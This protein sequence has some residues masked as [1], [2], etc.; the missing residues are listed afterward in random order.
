[1]GG[2]AAVS[3]P[4]P[5]PPQS[6][7]AAVHRR[8]QEL[9]FDAVGIVRPDSIAEAGGRL[10]TFLAEGRHGTMTW[11]ARR[12]DERADPRALWT[13]TRSVVVVGMN[14]PPASDPLADTR[15]PR[16]GT[17]ASYARGRDYHDV[18]KRRLKQLG[19]WLAEEFGAG[20]KV[21]VDTAPVLEKALSE[22][23]GLG[24]QGKHTNL[25]SRVFGSWL[26]LGEVFTTL[27]LPPDSPGGDAC[28]TCRRCLEIC[29]T[30]AFPAP[31]QLD[32]RRCISYLTIE[33]KGHIAEE[34]RA[35]IGNRVFGCDDCL[36]VCPWNKYAQKAAEASFEAREETSAPE[37]GD[38]AALDDASFRR[39]FAGTTVKRTG[40]HR[41]VRNVL[42]AV[43]NS[44]DPRLSDA[45]RRL[46]DDESPLVRAMAVWALA[47][48]DWRAFAA[49]RERLR[50]RESDAAV[51]AE[52][53]A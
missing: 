35:A 14:C 27:E 39:R 53:D 12:A 22:R 47:R 37:L 34:Y 11:M 50:D 30:D 8:A 33:H 48:L 4:D 28:G 13:D 5:A 21:F 29:P 24:W 46:L 19:G 25:V 41:F 26:L 20:V 17:I 2:P 9:G 3:P 49:E 1:M 31:Y 38:L 45:A 44:R 15:R 40:R 16:R 42:I 36:A 6:I 32:A 51:R 18:M 10:R 52:W 7:A 23:A 43:G